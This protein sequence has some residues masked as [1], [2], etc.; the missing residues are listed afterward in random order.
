MSQN[1][2]HPLLLPFPDSVYQ[3]SVFPY[4]FKDLFIAN[5]LS[6][7]RHNHILKHSWIYLGWVCYPLDIKYPVTLVG[8]NLTRLVQNLK[9]LVNIVVDRLKQY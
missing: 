6:I 2:P 9:A 3:L 8:M 5:F 7:L 4:T 1:V